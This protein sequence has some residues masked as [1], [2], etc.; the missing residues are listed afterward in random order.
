MDARNSLLIV[1]LYV[2]S[3][4]LIAA[5]VIGVF[6]WQ[7]YALQDQLARETAAASQVRHHDV[8]LNRPSISQ[9]EF[10]ASQSA[11]EVER[12]RKLLDEQ[13]AVLEERNRLLKQRT[14]EYQKLKRSFASATSAM[15]QLMENAEAGTKDAAPSDDASLTATEGIEEAS[16]SAEAA[17]AGETA[18]LGEAV[19]AALADGA[20]STPAATPESAE[21]REELNKMRI[22]ETTLAEE[23]ETLEAEVLA[24]EMEI[25]RLKE[26][27]LRTQSE[28]AMAEERVLRDAASETLVRIGEAAVPRL[29]EAL[30]DERPAV[31]RWAAEV[32]TEMG[33]RADAAIGPLMEA[34]GDED[35]EVRLAAA[36]ALRAMGTND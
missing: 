11:Q 15:L 32:L 19:D 27:A 12:L 10:L 29:V 26:E 3:G 35:T 33:P 14:A 6:Y 36:Q 2:F 30:N 25:A 17:Q 7:G 1:G 22:L 16:E 18:E 23:L 28:Q 24:A 9:Q 13:T 5:I 34:L 20:A 8:L 4:L 21:L 31:R